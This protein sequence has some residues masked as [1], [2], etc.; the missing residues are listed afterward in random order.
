MRHS[1][2]LE[3]PNVMRVGGTRTP[4]PWQGKCWFKPNL[5]F[6]LCQQVRSDTFLKD[7][8]ISY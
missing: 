7:T 6:K 5:L 3:C 1:N 8:I 2:A 4:L